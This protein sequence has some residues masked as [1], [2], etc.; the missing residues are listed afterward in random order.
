[1][2]KGDE[3]RTICSGDE[4]GGDERWCKLWHTSGDA[5]QNLRLLKIHKEHAMC[6][7]CLCFT[8]RQTTDMYCL[9]N[10]PFHTVYEHDL[11]QQKNLPIKESCLHF[12]GRLFCM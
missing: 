3:L 9:P 6:A 5:R 2:T 8:N 7:H 11:S 10:C 4:I 1:M 12:A